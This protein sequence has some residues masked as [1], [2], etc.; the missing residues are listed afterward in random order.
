MITMVFNP[1]ASGAEVLIP[2]ED[3]DDRIEEGFVPF[4]VY[5]ETHG[6]ITVRMPR[7]VTYGRDEELSVTVPAWMGTKGAV[8]VFVAALRE[9][10]RVWQKAQTGAAAR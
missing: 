2:G 10:D 5:P 1:D 6:L 3:L 8:S 7:G 4:D 9:Y